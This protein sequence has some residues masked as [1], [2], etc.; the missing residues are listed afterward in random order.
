MVDVSAN[1]Q[2]T[3]NEP[4]NVSASFTVTDPNGNT[5]FTST[6]VPVSL[7]DTTS[8]ATVDLGNVDTTGFANGT[9]TITVNLSSGG[10]ATTPLFIGQPVTG[11]VTTTPSVIPTGSDTVSTTVTVS[12]QA[13]YPAPLTLEGGV[14]TPSPGTSVAL[15]T[16]GG[17]TYAYESG[18]DGI[19]AINVTDPTNPQ[20]IEVFG[21]SN[22]VDGSSGFNVAKVVDGYLIV[23]TTLSF[24]AGQFNLLVF[25]LADPTNPTLVSNTS[26]GQQFLSDLFVNS[27]G[28]EAF[29]PLDGVYLT[30]PSP[31]TI[32]VPLRQ[33]RRDRSQRSDRADARQPLVQRSAI[34]DDTGLSQFGGTLVN[35]QTAYVTGLTPGGGDV[36]DNTGNLLVVNV[37]DPT[38]MTI[39]TSA[40]NPQHRLPDRR[41]GVRERDVGD[42]QAGPQSD[43]YN[44]STT[45]VYDYLSLTLLDITDPNNPTIVGQTFVTPE[46]FPVNEQGQK[47]DVVSLGN[48]D[49]AV[50]DTDANGNPALLVID[51][52]NPNDMIVGAAQVPSG[53]H[54][55]TVSGDLLY[56]STSTGLS[57]YQIQPLVSDPVTVT[58]NLPAG[59]AANIV[60]GSFNAPPSQIVTSATGD[61][62]IW[63][64]SF[65]SGN[66]TYSFTWQTTVSGVTAGEVVPIVT[67]ARCRLPGPGDAR[68]DRPGGVVGHRDLD[69]QRHASVGNGPAGGHGNVRCPPDQ[70]DRRRRSPTT[71]RSRIPRTTSRRRP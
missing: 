9:D 34:P 52:S 2:A 62:L 6:A 18:T 41:G 59:T 30:G 17:Q 70:P 32:Y 8:V 56:A 38:N 27:T 57:I 65:A 55:I 12:T 37:S 46:Q 4:T 66:T 23:A 35:D 58:V 24:N 11:S 49:F 3:V 26:I 64:R 31:S 44:T 5:L 36:T 22:T 16:S 45:G 1:I 7:T 13:S 71:C 10:S 21:Q 53:V 51:P 25:S 48:G 14:T 28:T 15:Y 54:G 39:T 42:R 33:F 50:S 47:T 29:V 69:H 19:D 60:A 20:L 40:R 63:D 68:L 67:G 61:Q 43:V